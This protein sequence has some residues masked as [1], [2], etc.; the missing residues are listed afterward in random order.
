[1]ALDSRANLALQL[2]AKRPYWTRA[3]IYQELALAKKARIQCG[4]TSK[5]LDCF[6]KTYERLK[7]LVVLHATGN[8]P[9]GLAAVKVLGHPMAHMLSMIAQSR[10][11][12]PFYFD[13][14]PLKLLSDFRL[15]NATDPRDKVFALLGFVALDS[16]CPNLITVNYEEKVE[17]VYMDVTQHLILT[18]RTLRVL[19]ITQTRLS[20]GCRWSIPSWVPHWQTH[21][22]S[23]TWHDYNGLVNLEG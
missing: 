11:V 5:P 18:E 16:P 9:M 22:L 19:D 6:L 1:M 12:K 23:T 7:V 3:W 10:D 15:F 2:V 17:K 4:R 13:R 14:L 8:A 20:T 21:S